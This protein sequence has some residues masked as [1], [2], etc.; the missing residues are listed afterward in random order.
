MIGC[1][2]DGTEQPSLHKPKLE[3]TEFTWEQANDGGSF[4]WWNN[5]A[6][7]AM[8]DSVTSKL[9]VVST[10]GLLKWSYRFTYNISGHN[11]AIE[12]DSQSPETDIGT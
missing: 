3:R 2:I 10:N 1:I 5:D 11:S 12:V 7:N 6:V 9:V 4:W 8:Y